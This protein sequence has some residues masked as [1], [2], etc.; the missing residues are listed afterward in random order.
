MK[1]FLIFLLVVVILVC[2]WF[3]FGLWIGL[4]SIY[5]YPPSADHPDGA[6]LLVSRE[7]WEPMFNSPDYKAPPRKE[8]TNQGSIRF[9]SSAVAKKPVSVRTIVEFPYV[10]WAY[11]KSLEA[12]LP[13]E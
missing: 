3:A 11:K 6:T 2:G 9:G 10:E 4:Y 13:D 12:E 1:K 7:Q 5:S 8:A